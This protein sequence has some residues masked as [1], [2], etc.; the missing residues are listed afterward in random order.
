M[1]T[2]LKKDILFL[3]IGFILGTGVCLPSTSFRGAW[4]P[5][6]QAFCKTQLSW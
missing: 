2:E 1:W 3:I 5:P 4:W 6:V